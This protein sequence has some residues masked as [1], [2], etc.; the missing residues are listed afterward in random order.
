MARPPTLV[1]T[2]SKFVSLHWKHVVCLIAAHTFLSCSRRLDGAVLAL[3]VMMMIKAKRIFLAA[4]IAEKLVVLDQVCVGAHS[5][6]CFR[7][8]CLGAPPG[9]ESAQQQL[10]VSHRLAR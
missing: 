2:K 8:D 3:N 4:L 7:A 9:A 5:L 10:E 1:T 6:D